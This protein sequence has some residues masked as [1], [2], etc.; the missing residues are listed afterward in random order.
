M[1]D[2]ENGRLMENNLKPQFDLEEPDDELLRWAER[3]IGENPDTKP[4]LIEQLR[5][6]IF[7]RGECVPHRT[8]DAFLLKFLR[9]R[10]FHVRHAHRLIVNYYKLKESTPEF[11][12]IDYEKLVELGRTDVFN[13]PPNTDQDGRR[14]MVIRI[15]NWDTSKYTPVD[16][17]QAVIL[18]LEIALTEP[19][20]QLLG[21][22]CI[23]DLSGLS[24]GQAWYMSPTVARQM[25]QVGFS[26]MP[27]RAHAIHVVNHSWVFDMAFSI[28]QPFLAEVMKERIY[29]HDDLD[30]LHRHIE[31]K[32]LPKRYGGVYE[33]H[34]YITW[35][36]SLKNN[37]HVIDELTSLGYLG[38]REVIQKLKV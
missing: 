26:A 29:F 35:M 16:L 24:I 30:S 9:A 2:E 4:E 18:I 20:V 27:F 38:C 13:T 8:D 22:V 3:N 36:D 12:D 19:K 31:P 10:H 5:D 6:M 25:T 1:A 28:L 14:L 15:G 21:G 32:H 37:D 7:Q 33:D 23:F 34:K 11:F 17:F